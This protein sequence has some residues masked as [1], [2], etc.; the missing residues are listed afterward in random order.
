MNRQMSARGRYGQ[1]RI[2]PR[3]LSITEVTSLERV[4]RAANLIALNDLSCPD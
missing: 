1:T 2:Y 3:E 4:T